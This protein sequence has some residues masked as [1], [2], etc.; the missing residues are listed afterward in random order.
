LT[1]IMAKHN[2]SAAELQVILNKESGVAGVSGVSSDMREID[3]AIAEGNERAALALDMYLL[4]LVKYI[5]AYVAEMGG[6]DI[7]VFTGGVGENQ[8]GVRE[9]VCEQFKFIGLEIDKEFNA[10]VRGT[11]ATISTAGSKVKVC[12]IPTDEEYMIARDTE[13]IVNKL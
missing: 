1:Y 8:A 4:R 11:E 7:I 5:G 3:A 6:V 13:E 2:L 12:V 10:T 9:A